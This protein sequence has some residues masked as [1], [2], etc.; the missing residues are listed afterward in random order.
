M[1][2]LITDLQKRGCEF[3]AFQILVML[4]EYF[5]LMQRIMIHGTGL[6][7]YQA[8]PEIAFPCSDVKM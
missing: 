8:N 2:D 7:D 4:E 1:P 5:V 6:S 3:D